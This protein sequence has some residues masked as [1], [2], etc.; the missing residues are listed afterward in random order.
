M[1]EQVWLKCADPALMLAE[2]SGERGDERKLRLFAVACARRQQP[3]SHDEEQQLKAIDDAEAYADAAVDLWQ[4]TIAGA[5]AAREDPIGLGLSCTDLSAHHAAKATAA[6]AA[7][8]AGER[9]AQAAELA[10]TTDEAAMDAMRLIAAVVE[11]KQQADLLR[12]IVGNPFRDVPS[13]DP[14]WLA[15]NNGVIP[16]MARS[17]YEERAFERL[18]LL[19]DA[20]EEAGCADAAVLKHC[21][22]PGPHARG[23]SVVD[24]LLGKE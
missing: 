10:G 3:I 4:M 13:I 16:A 12:C 24:L 18:P 19:A 15:W 21:R 5:S 22:G 20:L 14:A 2:L 17:I 23:C 11:K 1:T 9:S 6:N 7:E 8:R